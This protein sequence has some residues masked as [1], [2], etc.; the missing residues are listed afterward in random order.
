MLLLLHYAVCETGMIYAFTV[1]RG[2]SRS[3]S[4]LAALRNR[5]V[6]V[7][8]SL[9]P[10]ESNGDGTINGTSHRHRRR[11]QV[12]QSLILVPL[13]WDNT[14]S[15]EQQKYAHAKVGSSS[16][17][18]NNISPDEA[19]DNLIQAREE[20]IT[21]AKEFLP[22]RKLDEM[23]DYL[24]NDD[25]EQQRQ[26]NK[27]EAN[28]QVLLESKKLDV[29]AKKAIGTIRRYGVGADVMIMYGGLKS[30]LEQDN[31][32]FAEVSKY[33]VKTL[34]SLEEVIVICRGSGFGNKK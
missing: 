13:L 24:L 9:L 22:N 7:S 34:D 29:E 4:S 27:Y 18:N 8:D 32:N 2:S 21:A 3:S 6:A 20:L 14:A 11:R 1:T 26:I 30:E 31:P 33:L 17:S 19:F 28:A 23:R 25:N 5:V 16:S 15:V 10:M 12:L